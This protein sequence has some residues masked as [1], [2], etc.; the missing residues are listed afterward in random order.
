[1]PL[2]E[3]VYWLDRK[4][5]RSG[6]I[7]WHRLPNF[8]WRQ[9]GRWSKITHD[10]AVNDFRLTI[11]EA[12]EQDPE[13]TLVDWVPKVE[14]LRDKD[15]VTYT[16]TDGSSGKRIIQPDGWFQV[17]KPSL[18]H[19]GKWAN[20]AFLVEIDMGTESNTRFGRDKVPAGVA[21]LKSE[22]YPSALA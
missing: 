22:L 8:E 20:Y 11:T 6:R 1:M 21:Y 19:P 15:T 13:L 5:P 12:C 3:T 17:K 7:E 18:R 9:A 10:L 14:F 4:G 16:Y 2:G